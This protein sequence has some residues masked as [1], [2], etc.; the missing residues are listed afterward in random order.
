[1]MFGPYNQR[2]R[3]ETVCGAATVTTVFLAAVVYLTL[4]MNR[5]INVY[6]EGFILFDAARVLDGD[7]PHRDFYTSY[8]PGQLY[9]LA[10]LYKIFGASVLVERAWDTFVR[11]CIV[12]L[13]LTVV[14]QVAPRRQALGAAAA[15]LVCLAAVGSYSYPVFPA[16]AASLAG[17]AFLA[18][19]LAR[20]KPAAGLIAAGVC[21]GAVM[22]FRY[23]VGIAIFGSE[24][25]VLA[26]RA[27]SQRLDIRHGVRTVIRLLS[28]FGVGFAVVVVPVA[29]AFVQNGVVPDL[30][31]QVVIFN[32]RFYA[33]TRGLPFPRP[34]TPAGDPSRFAVDLPLL[35]CATA[36]PAMVAIARHQRK[37]A[38]A[39]ESAEPRPAPAVILPWTVS[40]LVVMT[41]VFFAKSAVRVGVLGMAMSLITSMA[42]AGVL[43]QPVPGRGRVGRG[44]VALSLLAAFAF[45]LSCLH[46]GVDR[47]E[48]NFAWA[49]DPASWERSATG[50]VPDSGSCLMPPGLERLACFRVSPAEVET[51]RFVQ[52][53][54]A[55]GDPVFVGLVRHDKIFMNDVLMYFILNRRSVTKW[56]QFEPGLQTSAPIQQEIV[57]ELRHAK[58]RLIV[59]EANWQDLREPNDSGLSSGVTVLDDYIRDAFEPV[60]TFGTNTVLVARSSEQP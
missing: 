15:T 42:L 60:A 26:F 31:F 51:I 59:L 32:A 10:A 7:I 23:D 45:T 55:P 37:K 13:V 9:V 24:C 58:P 38:G 14:N 25:A 29:A 6:D 19:S 53:R 43:A 48:Q 47:A 44:M 52:Q 49:W 22:L 36:V 34:W 54:T 46:D 5:N 12:A 1:M 35:L 20:P 21:A 57:R 27:W 8:G 30:I 3:A 11:S 16:L 39:P 33:K 28:W 17:L 18:P 50:V 4:C 41:L 40:T 2:R 56:H